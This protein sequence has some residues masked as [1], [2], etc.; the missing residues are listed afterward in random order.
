MP[1]ESTERAVRELEDERTKIMEQNSCSFTEAQLAVISDRL[2]EDSRRRRVVEMRAERHEG[3]PL[4]VLNAL[5]SACPYCQ[6]KG[7]IDLQDPEVLDGE[8]VWIASCIRCTAF[9]EA[10][11][12]QQAFDHW[13]RFDGPR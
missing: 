8:E 9:V 12:P 10:S 3:M 7:A 4:S 5:L 13:N 1:D 11:S 2:E 6:F